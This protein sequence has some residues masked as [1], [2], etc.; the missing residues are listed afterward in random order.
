VAIGMAGRCVRDKG[1]DIFLDAVARL[2]D[3]QITCQLWGV[4]DSPPA[5]SYPREILVQLDALPENLR[6]RIHVEPFRADIHE[7]FNNCDIVVVPSRFAEPFGRMAIE[8]MACGKTVVAAAHGGLTEIVED[9][10]NGRLFTPGDA[11]ALAE[12]LSQLIDSPDARRRLAAKAS[13][14]AADRFSS[15]A[16]CDAVIRV[17]STLPKRRNALK[18][19]LNPC[20]M[21]ETPRP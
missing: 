3:R 19:F 4:P 6:R 9:D 10:F 15:K 11:A 14:D 8:A 16:H 7:F 13:S 12:V 1:F 17:Y 20:P 21:M 2:E 5:G 18:V